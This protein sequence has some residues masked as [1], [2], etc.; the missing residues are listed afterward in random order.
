[1]YLFDDV[2]DGIELGKHI[3]M[4][5]TI[6]LCAREPNEDEIKTVDVNISF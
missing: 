1:M 6:N 4:S 2:E 3:S 5:K